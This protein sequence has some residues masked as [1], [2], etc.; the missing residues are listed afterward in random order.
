MFGT[1]FF[2]ECRQIWKNLT[3][4]ILVAGLVFFYGSQMGTI[5]PL[6][7]PMPGQEGSYGTKPSEDPDKVVEATLALLAR[8]YEENSYAAY[9]VGFYKNVVLNEEKSE[10]VHEI[11]KT[12]TGLSEG[13]TEAVEQKEAQEDSP[14]TVNSS[15]EERLSPREGLKYE[16][17]LEEM[18]KV[19]SILGGGS[20]YSRETV[21]ENAQ[22]P[23]T[24]EEAMESY[25]KSLYE[26]KISGGYARLFCDYMGILLALLPVFLA[27]TRSLR[28]KRAQVDQVIYARKISSGAI[29]GSRY[30][31]A[32]VMISIPVLLI[33]M[34]P[35]TQ[36]IY[37]GKVLGVSVDYLAFLKY[38]GGWLL[39]SIAV[40][41]AL[42]FFL[43]ELTN[44]PVAILVQ[45]VWWMISLFM[46][47]E[48]LVGK[49]GWNLMPR[50]NSSADTM[51]WQEQFPQMI[52][53]RLLYV[54]VA[55]VL[56]IAA[57][58]VY[59]LKRKGVWGN[60]RKISGSHKR[61]S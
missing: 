9:P 45:G 54:A 40:V 15:G 58:G 38:F 61:I 12:C 52:R 42:G 47:A 53:N 28:D 16:E 29:M 55:V 6:V 30:L 56:M 18:S 44:G 22:D 14:V 19:D 24:Y 13:Y 3:Y 50:F 59:H 7:K 48:N 39:P 1:L 5:S 8:E 36:C 33:G 17:F 43:T 46:G 27:V 20:S 35:L 51:V 23:L 41:T 2:K 60:G 49:V 25:Q 34:M 31:A 21:N 57:T 4:Y 10:K 26:D 32:V 11:L 37:Y